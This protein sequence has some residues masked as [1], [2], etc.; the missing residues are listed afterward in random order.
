MHI[1][2]NLRTMWGKIGVL[3]EHIARGL[4][5]TGVAIGVSRKND[6][7]TETCRRATKT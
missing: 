4:V 2:Y 5:Q 6:I 1:P 7:Y 3:W